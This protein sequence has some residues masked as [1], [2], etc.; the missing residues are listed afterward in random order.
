MRRYFL[1]AS[2]DENNTG[3]SSDFPRKNPYKINKK[4][5][6]GEDKIFPYLIPFEKSVIFQDDDNKIEN[7][8]NSMKGKIRYVICIL[9]END[10]YNNSQMLRRTLN[11]FIDYI[12]S[13][14]DMLI[15]HKNILIV[16]FLKNLKEQKFLMKMIL[17]K[18]KKLINIF[19]PKNI[20]I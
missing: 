7:L 17:K 2:N 15:T 1:R 3:K 18:L 12:I 6:A 11:S 20:T 8:Y 14:K 13:L 4:E 9:I 10:S 5:I 16:Y 19:Y